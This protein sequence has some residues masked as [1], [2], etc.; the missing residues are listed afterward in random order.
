MRKNFFRINIFAYIF[1][2]LMVVLNKVALAEEICNVNGEV[3]PC[4]ELSKRFNSFIPNWFIV[5]LSI[6]LILFYVFCFVFW[7][8]MLIHA[9]KHDIDN[10]AM[11]IIIIAITGII[12]AVIYY[13]VV[14]RKFDKKLI[15]PSPSK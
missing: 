13:F 5:L 11:W 12:G 8:L 15:P 9:A 14:K 4:S 6:S 3:V 2:G 7:I 1:L 10:K